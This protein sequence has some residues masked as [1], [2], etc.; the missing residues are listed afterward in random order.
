MTIHNLAFQGQYPASL[1]GPL[2]LPPE[3]FSID[4]V[5]YYGMI[6]FLKGALAYSDRITTVSPT[7][8]AE[9]RTPDYGM[10]L[11]GLLRARGMAVSGI[12]N[13]DRRGGLGSR[14]PTTSSKS[15]SASRRWRSGQP[16]RRPAAKIR[17]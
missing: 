15:R 14:R 3:A 8:A 2:G 12:L 4:G 1:L 9:I 10:G 16:T 7:Y 11:D 17:P 5:E 6:G 13:G